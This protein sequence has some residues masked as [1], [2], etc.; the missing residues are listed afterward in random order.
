MTSLRPNATFVSV[1]HIFVLSYFSCPAYLWLSL[2]F[3]VFRVHSHCPRS[4]LYL[5]IIRCSSFLF[6]FGFIWIERVLFC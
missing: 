5:W 6:G 2:S 4:W 1:H 3:T